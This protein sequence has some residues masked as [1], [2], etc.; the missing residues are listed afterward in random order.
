MG[1]MGHYAFGKY[2]RIIYCEEKAS[3]FLF[4]Y[5]TVLYLRFIYFNL[6]TYIINEFIIYKLICF[7][8]YGRR[9]IT[10]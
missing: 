1:L 10:S 9:I 3:S 6:V 2:T 5:R 8:N 7:R 4:T